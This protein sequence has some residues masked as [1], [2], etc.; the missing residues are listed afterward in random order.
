LS[1]LLYA[2]A[3]GTDLATAREFLAR[4]RPPTKAQLLVQPGGQHLTNDVVKMVPD[5]FAY[6]TAH[7]ARP[8]PE[9]P[10][11]VGARRS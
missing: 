10:G 11:A 1:V 4:V 3:D 5:A 9:T 8:T 6:L 2:G 7:L